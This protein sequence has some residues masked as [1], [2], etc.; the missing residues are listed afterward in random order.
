VE[1]RLVQHLT[2]VFERDLKAAKSAFDESVRDLD[3]RLAA[4]GQFGTGYRL[5]RSVEFMKLTAMDFLESM[6]A[7]AAKREVTNPFGFELIAAQIGEL[8][9]YFESRIPKIARNTGGGVST[10]SAD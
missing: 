8:Q 6:R 1:E 3:A 2:L 9:D 10:K 7:T 4:D 5:K